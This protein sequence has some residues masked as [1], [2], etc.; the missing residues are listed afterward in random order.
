MKEFTPILPWDGQADFANQIKSKLSE[1]IKKLNESGERSSIGF[2]EISKNFI[3]KA[4]NELGLKHDQSKKSFEIY[5]LLSSFSLYIAEFIETH[6]EELK[7]GLELCNLD[8]DCNNMIVLKKMLKEFSL[9][10]AHLQICCAICDK[11]EE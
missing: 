3:K 10:T 6:P 7:S 8:L 9:L 1:I 11:L 5:T 2:L 4:H